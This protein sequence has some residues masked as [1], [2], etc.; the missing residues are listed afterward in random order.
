MLWGWSITVFILVI[1][2]WGLKQPPTDV[3][4]LRGQ[5]ATGWLWF[6]FFTDFSRYFCRKHVEIEKEALLQKWDLTS[7]SQFS[8]VG[9]GLSDPM[10]MG[11]STFSRWPLYNIIIRTHYQIPQNNLSVHGNRGLE[12]WV[13]KLTGWNQRLLCCSQSWFYYEGS[14]LVVLTKTGHSMIGLLLHK[15]ASESL[16]NHWLHFQNTYMMFSFHWL[17]KYCF[18]SLCVYSDQLWQ[19]SLERWSKQHQR[20]DT[21]L[22]WLFWIR[23][24]S[25]S[26]LDIPDSSLLWFVFLHKTYIEDACA[27]YCAYT[28]W[29]R[30]GTLQL[31]D[32]HKILQTTPLKKLFVISSF[33]L[34]ESHAFLRFR[35]KFL[36]K[37]FTGLGYNTLPEY[38]VVDNKTGNKY[39]PHSCLHTSAPP[40]A[41]AS[42]PPCARMLPCTL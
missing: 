16:S 12:N 13:R 24:W 27:L 35:K 22:L 41:T 30:K 15:A 39:R 42:I 29:K 20:E 11:K 33:S 26:T 32:H 38:L 7:S 36:R 40:L 9:A 28:F 19:R 21:I 5:T 3:A 2:H 25:R 1:H 14:K 10:A 6:R 23:S 17:S 4:W 37:L 8:D 34:E 31:V 18:K